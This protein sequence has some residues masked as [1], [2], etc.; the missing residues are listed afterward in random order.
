MSRCKQKLQFTESLLAAAVQFR[1][2]RLTL[3]KRVNL[4]IPGVRTHT[5]TENLKMES[6]PKRAIK[7]CLFVFGSE[8]DP[9]FTIRM[10]FT[11]KNP[12]IDFGLPLSEK[13]P[14]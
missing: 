4:S 11:N 13:Q 14:D 12:K 2:S 3:K 10:E 1:G 5:H 9:C 6:T 8:G 7:S